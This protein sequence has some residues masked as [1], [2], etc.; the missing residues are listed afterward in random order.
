M[1]YFLVKDHGFLD[2]NKRIAATL[3]VYFLAKNG[4]LR[5]NN[6]LRIDD[7]S[8]AALTLLIAESKAEEKDLI[9]SFTLGVITARGEEMPRPFAL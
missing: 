8:L 9:L 2:G 6:R 1:L 3:F 7:L 5:V 4:A